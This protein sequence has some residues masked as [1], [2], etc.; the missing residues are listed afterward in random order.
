[1]VMAERQV[2]VLAEKAVNVVRV[3]LLSR[4]VKV[5]KL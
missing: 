2:R 4:A 1:M 3:R 5:K